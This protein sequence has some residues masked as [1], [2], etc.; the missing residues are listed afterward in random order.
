MEYT[1]PDIRHCTS[2]YVQYSNLNMLVNQ[3]FHVCARCCASDFLGILLASELR[4][5][6]RDFFRKTSQRTFDLSRLSYEHI[7]A[8]IK[9]SDVWFIMS[10]VMRCQNPVKRWEISKVIPFFFTLFYQFWSQTI[11]PRIPERRTTIPK[12]PNVEKAKGNLKCWMMSRVN[13]GFDSYSYIHNCMELHG[14]STIF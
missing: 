7:W 10:L 3:S 4:V 12:T 14:N 5:E 2:K 9:A 1:T 8:S 6:F 13:R 11:K